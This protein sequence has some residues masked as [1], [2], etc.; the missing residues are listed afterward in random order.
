MVCRIVLQLI[1][2]VR[3]VVT[4]GHCSAFVLNPGLDCAIIKINARSLSDSTGREI[5]N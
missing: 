3:V 1:F 2:S 5:S 4:P